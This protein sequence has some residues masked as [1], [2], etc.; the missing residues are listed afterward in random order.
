MIH[1]LLT[2]IGL[3]DSEAAMYIALLRHGQQATTFLSQKIG[4]NRGLGYVVLHSLLQK[5]LVT[6]MSRGKVQYFSPLPPEHLVEYLEH[7]KKEIEGKQE[8]V[9][10]MLSQLVAITNPLMTKPKMRFFDGIEGARAVLESILTSKDKTL[11]AYLSLAD[12]INFVGSDFFHTFA[13]RLTKEGFAL[14]AIRTHEKDKQALALDPR[15]KRLGPSKK[16]RRQIRYAPENLAFPMTMFLSDDKLVLLS[17]K[18]ENFALLI[19]SREYL[20]MQKKLFELVWNSLERTTIRVGV[21]HS[22]SG[23]MAISERSLVDGILLAID[24]INAKGGILGRR[25]DP[26]VVDGASDPE[27]FAKQAEFLITSHDVCSVFGGWTSASRKEMLPVFEKHGH[28]LWYPVQYEG[29]EQS[30]NIMYTGAAPNQQVLPAVD[31]AVKHL[32]KKFFLVGSDYVFPRSAHE[33]MKSR[34]EELGGTVVGEAYQKLGGSEFRDIVKKIQKMKPDVILNTINGDSNI[35]FFRELR[36][37]GISPKRIPTISFSIGEEEVSR[38]YPES[39]AGD[40]AAWSYFQS[41]DSKENRQFVKNFQTKYGRHRVTGDPIETAYICVYLFAEAVEKAGTDD[42]AHV[43]EAARGL[44]FA[45]PEGSVRIDPDNQHLHRFARI[46]K[47]REDGQFTIVWSSD[48]TIKPDPYPKY[49]S[50]AEWHAF[51]E[52]LRK[53]WRGHWIK[54]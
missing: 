21:L 36:A 45:A 35:D 14:H 49:K 20:E 11:R 42:V 31:W 47:I 27:I 8:R 9:Q 51:L 22:L 32:G 34:I 7:Q 48:S 40:Y 44:R 43:R 26:I 30:P 38:M 1:E 10:T 53:G 41:I 54:Q 25:I 13:S 24:E 6:K 5:G 33:I 4:V 50:K 12:A 19:E 52:D 37:R 23:T 18:E 3:S 2:D 15:L 46:G 39:M 28:L 17:S 29:L 16:E